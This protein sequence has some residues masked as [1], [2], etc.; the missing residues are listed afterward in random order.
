MSYDL[1]RINN[2]S[3]LCATNQSA[4]LWFVFINLPIM[5]CFHSFDKTSKYAR[6]FA[7]GEVI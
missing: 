7:T 2:D 1:L 4:C 6:A 3:Y 5:F